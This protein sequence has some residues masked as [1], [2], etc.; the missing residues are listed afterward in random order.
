VVTFE[1]EGVGERRV[2]IEVIPGGYTTVV[3][4]EPR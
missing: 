2:P 4:T 3:V 1:G